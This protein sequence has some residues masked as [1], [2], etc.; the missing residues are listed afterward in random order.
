MSYPT[1]VR[2]SIFAGLRCLAF[3]SFVEINQ[4]GDR[5]DVGAIGDAVFL[6][7]SLERLRREIVPAKLRTKAIPNADVA[8]IVSRNAARI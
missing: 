1:P 5:D 6:L 7:Q 4:V 8:L 3:S 2:A